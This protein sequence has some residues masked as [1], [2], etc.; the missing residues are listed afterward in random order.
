VVETSAT[1][2]VI[3]DDDLVRDALKTLLKSAG[4][5]VEVFESAQAFLNS[6]HYQRRG[7]LVLDVRMPGMDGL[8]LQRQLAESGIVIPII[9]ISAHEDMQA[10]AKAMAAGAVAFLQKPFEDHTLLDAIERTLRV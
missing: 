8:E 10:R 9:F 5:K 3:D 6:G 4:F 1:V 7:M 2:L